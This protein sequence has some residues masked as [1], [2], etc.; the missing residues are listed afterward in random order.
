MKNPIYKQST[1]TLAEVADK[2]GVSRQ[3][4]GRILGNGAQKHKAA[5]VEKVRQMAEELGYRPNLLA[6]SVVAGRTY[7]IGILLPYVKNDNYFAQII[8]GIQDVLADSGLVPILLYTSNKIPERKQIHQLVDRRVDGIILVPHINQVDPDYFNEIT[9]R[10]IPVVCV[11]A[12]LNNIKPVDF[13]GTDEFAGG[14]MAAEF[15][16]SQGHTQ[17]CSVHYDGTSENLA[18]RQSG[19]QHT[20][21]AKKASCYSLKLPGWTPEENLETIIDFLKQPNRP[22]AFFCISDLYAAQLYQAAEQLALR[23][24]DDLSVVG[25]ADLHLAQYLSPPLTT[26]RQDGQ[27]IG[28]AATRRLMQ[29]ME[30]ASGAPEEKTF[31]A[32]MI[33]RN[34]VAPIG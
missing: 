13:V 25:F 3:T 17:L 16:L 8:S 28:A 10:N 15:L 21:E 19:F 11:N 29:R 26:L 12:R 1:A 33:I 4:A 32:E 24:P 9:D 34:S 2:A 6:K 23:I 30:G 14:Q 20:T 5:T 27:E 31:R 7:S 22:S 18:Q